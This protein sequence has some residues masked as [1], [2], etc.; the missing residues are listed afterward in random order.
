MQ[1]PDPLHV[2][3]GQS[4]EG[5]R[6][7]YAF[8]IP[9][10]PAGDIGFEVENRGW[11][12]FL[13][14]DQGRAE[15]REPGFLVLE[16]PQ[17]G[18]APD[19]PLRGDLLALPLVYA[20]VGLPDLIRVDARAAVNRPSFAE[21]R[22]QV[23]D[24]WLQDQRRRADAALM[25]HPRARYRI[26]LAEPPGWGRP[27]RGYPC[28]C[29]YAAGG[30][31]KFLFVFEANMAFW[32]PVQAPGILRTRSF[33]AMLACAFLLSR[34]AIPAEAQTIEPL[35][36]VH[37]RPVC[38]G[39]VAP[40]SARCHSWVMVGRDGAAIVSASSKVP[41]PRGLRPG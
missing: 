32:R 35:S 20:D 19:R 13:A 1:Y 40:I 8:Q 26:E 27:P 12:A 22:P 24:A 38:P 18:A 14:L 21:I 30:I 36:G 3:A 31:V 39:P 4:V 34:A 41:P 17:A 9:L 15:G 5:D 6:P 23:R 28:A 16:Q 25:D 2:G 29:P 37:F 7:L 11:A 10:P 33:T